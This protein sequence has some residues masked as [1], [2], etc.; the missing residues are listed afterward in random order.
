MK[1]ITGPLGGG[2]MRDC[3]IDCE[4]E[5]T[6]VRAAIAYAD[7]DMLDFF[8]S[9]LTN[10]KA[11]DFY[12]RYDSTVPIDPRILRWFIERANLD[13][14]CHLVGFYPVFADS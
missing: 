6:A 1:L 14:R 11:L 12:G 8:K 9:S 4:K 2:W 7:W 3:L 10:G 5:C 13:L